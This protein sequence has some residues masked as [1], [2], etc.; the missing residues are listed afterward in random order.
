MHEVGWATFQGGLSRF[1]AEVK[2]RLT[3]S[4]GFSLSRGLTLAASYKPCRKKEGMKNRVRR[5]SNKRCKKNQAKLENSVHR[6]LEK[7]AR[8]RIYKGQKIENRVCTF[9]KKKKR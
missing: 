7:N 4:G 9:K 6:P 2:G 8:H 3:F 5:K 1:G